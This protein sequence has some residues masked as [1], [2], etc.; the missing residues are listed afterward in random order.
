MAT[1]TIDDWGGG[2]A[3]AVPASASAPSAPLASG[4]CDG[5]RMAT[6]APP[7]PT[8]ASYD[9]G[10]YDDDNDE[11]D[12]DVDD[13]DVFPDDDLYCQLCR[14]RHPA[15]WVYAT[16]SCLPYGSEVC[17]SGTRAC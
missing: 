2:G 7:M 8:A 1:A 9:D 16:S 11:Y 12:D 6:A 15:S 14:A 17:A 3:A 4:C 5:A 13:D 10:E